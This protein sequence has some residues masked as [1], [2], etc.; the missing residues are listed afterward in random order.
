M[1]FDAK[2]ISQGIILTVKVPCLFKVR[3]MA[4]IRNLYNQA[5]HMK[6]SSNF[7]TDRS[8][9]VLLL[10]ILFCYLCFVRVCHT[11]LSVL[12]SLLVTDWERAD[13]LAL[14]YVMFS[15]VLWYLIVSIPDPCL[16]PY[17]HM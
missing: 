5:P 7:S 3:K 15:Y 9:A 2:M 11:A 10:W 16:L 6:S 13:L 14:L 8:K 4:K 17:F 1:C 12:C